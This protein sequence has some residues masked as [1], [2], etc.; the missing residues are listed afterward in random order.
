MPP[1]ALRDT[2]M[3]LAPAGQDIGA[4]DKASWKQELLHWLVSVDAFAQSSES[5][6]DKIKKQAKLQRLAAL[7]FCVALDW[8]IQAV[9]GHGL[10]HFIEPDAPGGGEAKPMGDKS[11]LLLT[12][13]QGS[14]GMAALWF[15]M[16]VHMR[17]FPLFDLCHRCHNDALNAVKEAG[18]HTSLL[19]TII[20]FNL[21]Y[22]PFKGQSF[23]EQQC[24]G[25]KELV[26]RCS[27]DDP[28]VLHY[29]PFILQEKG[30][31]DDG[32]YTVESIKEDLATATWLSVK[33]P[34]VAMSRWF[35]WR[36][37]MRFWSAEWHL[38]LLLL[39]FFGLVDGWMNTAK[40]MAGMVASLK[41]PQPRSSFSSAKETTKESKAHADRLRDRCKNSMH[42]TAVVMSDERVLHDTRMILA[43]T[44][45]SEA[46]HAYVNTSLRSADGCAKF[47]AE[48]AY[49]PIAVKSIWE[50]TAVMKDLGTLSGC[51]FIVEFTTGVVKR[52]SPDDPALLHQ[53][54]LC[55]RLCNLICS[56]MKHRWAG[57]QWVMNT[58]PA[59]FFQLLHPAS[60]V[61][62][63]AHSFIKVVHQASVAA[64]GRPEPFWK[65]LLARSCMNFQVVKDLMDIAVRVDFQDHD[66][67]RSAVLRCAKQ[68]G[69]TVICEEGFQRTRRA[70]EDNGGASSVVQWLVPSRRKI[71]STL[72]AYDEVDLASVPEPARAASEVTPALF[73]PNYSKVS[74]PGML[75]ALPGTGPVRWHS[76]NGKNVATFAADLALLMHCHSNDKMAEAPSS[77]K[78]AWLQKGILVIRVVDNSVFWSLGSVGPV[79][80]LWPAV[81]EPVGK[82]LVYAF[83]DPGQHGVFMMPCLS[84]DDFKVIPTEWQS[85]LELFL[86]MEKRMPD[87]WPNGMGV[88]TGNPL[89]LVEFS[90]RKAF[91]QIELPL[92]EKFAREEL[93]IRLWGTSAEKLFMLIQSILKCSDEEAADILEQRCGTFIDDPGH[94]D[95]LQS[96]EAEDCMDR[97][98]QQSVEKI[99]EQTSRKKAA[100]DE[101]SPSL[102]IDQD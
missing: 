72:H 39:T 4:D 54:F 22:G 26:G 63:Q 6:V 64:M 19:L 33:G 7:D 56:M 78:S 9:A 76:V 24:D 37:A 101:E 97:D 52:M 90:A 12:I 43:C 81:E 20:I 41:A 70:E 77:W 85:P 34:R 71:L 45:P 96:A 66:E 28:L 55:N 35:T 8:M 79:A 91:W 50:V 86:A 99:V 40:S 51:G 16:S 30:L 38:R 31:V 89:G 23:W 49:G 13:D 48:L 57:L 32:S 60:Q 15:M 14:I 58:L 87:E 5:E 29:L 11:M 10:V 75:K 88:R 2:R 25:A 18:M 17:M 46:W 1:Q 21:S 3:R 102:M 68:L 36:K 53:R 98:E 82:Q 94:A 59:K 80:V 93:D 65:K 69:S 84:F 83:A 42:L 100:A 95:L 61:R 44:G 47:Y 67:L 92:L 73:R 74:I 27:Q 62:E